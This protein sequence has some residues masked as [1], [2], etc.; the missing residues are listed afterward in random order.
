V[1][2]MAQER[3]GEAWGVDPATVVRPGALTKLLAD[4][5]R[6]PEA[7]GWELPVAPGTR[8]GRYEIV[9][10]IGRGG[11]GVV[12]EA[13]DA[14]L[15][16]PVA[17]K[18]IRGG[19]EE[20]A[21]AKRRQAEAEAEAGARLAHPN[22]VHL[23]DLGRVEQG[24]YLIMEL[25]RGRTLAQ[26]LAEGALP[27]REA[28]RVAVEI[29]RGVAHAHARGVVHRDLKPSNVFVCDDGQV[30]VL[31]FGL[32]S[33]LG[34]GSISGGTPGYMAPEQRRGEAGDERAD[35]YSLGVMVEE[36]TAGHH[37]PQ[38]L[39]RLTARMRQPDPASRPAHA[40]QVLAELTAIQK[41]LEPRRWLWASV[42]VATLALIGAAI[43]AWLWQRPLPEGRLLTA[44]ADTDNQT[45]DPQLDSVAELLR[46]GLEQSRRVSV[47]ARSHLAT[48][49]EATGAEPPAVFGEAETAKAAGAAGA[50]L[51]VVPSVRP[52]DGGYELQVR[53][54]DLSR[55][56]DWLVVRDTAGAKATV[57]A[58]VDRLVLK[59]RRALREEPGQAPKKAVAVGEAM[60][61]NPEALRL[62][63]EGW[64]LRREAASNFGKGGQLAIAAWR[65]AIEADPSFLQPRMELLE[66]WHGVDMSAAERGGHEQAIREGLHRLPE[67][68]R[69]YAEALLLS[70]GA[71]N[72]PQQLQL[73]E[74]AIEAK[75]EDPRPYR[76]LAGQVLGNQADL[77][78][79]RPYLEK[80]LELGAVGE[81]PAIDFL[82]SLGRGD[83]ALAR[84]R[85]WVERSPSPRSLSTLATAHRYRGEWREALEATRRAQALPTMYFYTIDYA[86]ADAW[87]LLEA[88]SCADGRAC[89]TRSDL[90][91]ER[92]RFREALAA[93]DAERPSFDA[94]DLKKDNRNNW[95]FRFDF[96]MPFEDAELILE[97]MER[98]VRHGFTFFVGH[99]VTL[100]LLGDVTRAERMGSAYA[101]H[102]LSFDR[103]RRAIIAWKRGDR[104]EALRDFAAI[105]LA[106][107][108]VLRGE[109]LIEMG[110]YREA[111]EAIHTYRRQRAGDVQDIPETWTY[112]QSLYLE[113]VALEKLGERDEARHA[114]GRLLRLW[115][116]A[117]PTLPLFQRAK[118]LEAKLA[119]ADGQK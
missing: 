83:E 115:K 75:P 117:D 45:G 37:P 56:Q 110:R 97:D 81:G 23:Y 50:A 89:N 27:L 16:R 10:E 107:S 77:E 74:R 84:A 64:R 79:A 22:I 15:G 12:Y 18:T 85:R 118:K 19:R 20:T 88:E 92:G 93:W 108:H 34:R 94:T 14:E 99:S 62:Y 36:L 101:A 80:A 104:E 76:K 72:I 1:A 69:P 102:L 60:S 63:Q 13:H 67:V 2:G 78:A 73:L 35:V 44:I 39:Q 11:F 113:A 4:L 51:L 86:D 48:I 68:E 96:L 119:V 32:A 100:A 3:A 95:A 53:A 111:V 109:I 8:L 55:H 90:L 58:A 17:F 54:V 49:V 28:V 91:A 25:L 116:K 6:A 29:T 59:V 57:P 21:E 41:S 40:G 46:A 106:S 5:A 47:M 105:H 66:W 30:K 70:H 26:K 65:R 82:L 9:R 87:D 33:V 24:A 7:A 71:E 31:D 43:F 98:A 61:A 114:L 103:L 112:P 42:G 52:K 38:A